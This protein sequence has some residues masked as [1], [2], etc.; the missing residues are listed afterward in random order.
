MANNIENI[1]ATPRYTECYASLAKERIIFVSELI[2]KSLASS[3]SALLLFYDA[4]NDTDDINLYIN[5]NGGDVDALTNI[6]DVMQMIKSPIKTVCIGK[7]YSAGSVILAAGT[8]GKR[9]MTKN[10]SVV[11]HGLQSNSAQTD[12]KEAEIYF[13]YLKGHHNMVLDILAKHTGQP[14]EKIVEDCKKDTYFDA[15]QALEYGI[16]DKI[17]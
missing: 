16:I 17:V 3:L 2:T 11:I 5:T 12:Q 15:T 14:I 7:A 13:K 6:Y 10:A 1:I 9:F 8:K 4:E